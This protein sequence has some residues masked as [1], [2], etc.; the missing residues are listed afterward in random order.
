MCLQ[1][2]CVL[3]NRGLWKWWD[4]WHSWILIIQSHSRVRGSWVYGPWSVPIG[5][6]F[7][8]LSETFQISIL[9]GFL[10]LSDR[11]LRT[12]QQTGSQGGWVDLCLTGLNHQASSCQGSK[13]F[14]DVLSCGW[15]KVLFIGI[16]QW[17]ELPPSLCL[18]DSVTSF[19][20]SDCL[21]PVLCWLQSNSVYP[22]LPVWSQ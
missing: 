8:R 3:T 2:Q 12:E 16:P 15:L 18:R 6:W 21:V 7:Y 19:S 1:W 17:G 22:I 10:L 5:Q 20:T 4:L 14:N 13:S 11:L 9:W